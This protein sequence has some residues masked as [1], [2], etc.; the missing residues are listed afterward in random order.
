[1]AWSWGV[2]LWAVAGVVLYV[3]A[4]IGSLLAIATIEGL[5]SGL[6]N[7]VAAGTVGLSI[8]NGLHPLVWGAL[9]AA[10][11]IPIGR[12][13]VDNLRFG[14]VGW[15]L[16]LI[17]LAFAAVTTFLVDEF[18]RARFGYFSPRMTG[19]TVFAGPALVAIALAAWAALA[20]PS[21]MGL[22][23]V[24][25]TVAAVASLALALAPSIGGLDDGIDPESLPLAVVFL[26]D[27]LFA[28]AAALLVLRT[29][30]ASGA[31]SGQPRRSPSCQS[32]IAALASRPSTGNASEMELAPT[33]PPPMPAGKPPAK[34]RA[35]ARLNG[36]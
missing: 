8:Q 36:P 3:L 9:V 19:L 10:A 22:P 7:L 35:A 1:M 20:V 29:A 5:V 15:F 28:A 13:L 25:A 16:L 6:R 23:L 11:S 31:D 2:A 32:S 26:L 30:L 27:V 4:A 18:V 12:R 33:P 17:G 24:A 21:G 14:A 34:S